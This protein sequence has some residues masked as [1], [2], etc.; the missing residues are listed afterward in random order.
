MSFTTIL[1]SIE[2]TVSSCLPLLKKWVEINSFSKNLQGL[3]QMAHSLFQD[4]SILKGEQELISLPSYP[5]C[6]P[7]GSLMHCETGLALR[8][9]KRPDAARQIFLAGHLDTVH[10]PSSTFQMLREQSATRWIGPGTADMKG[11]LFILLMA[12]M[13][14]EASF[15]ADRLGWEILITPDEEIG[16]ASSLNLL[17]EAAGR[18]QT[19]L[20]FEPAFPDGAFVSSRK[21][22]ATY[23]VVCRGQAAHVGREYT[24]GKSAVY[25]LAEWITAVEQLGAKYPESILNVAALEAKAPPNVVPDLS[26]CR[27]N[28]RSSS[29]ADMVDIEQELHQIA[30]RCNRRPGIRM[31]IERESFRGPKPFD[32][33]TETLFKEYGESAAC[34][35]IPFH[36]RPT[37]GV[38]DGNFLSEAGMAVLDSAGAVGGHIHTEEEYMDLPSITER[39]KLTALFLMKRAE[40]EHG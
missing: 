5:R 7:D 35:G 12:M 11:G 1:Q 40:A 8:I 26:I 23:A 14:F 28:S 39:A 18:Y 33:K 17:L 19:G 22:S 37:G 38:C 31:T 6:G 15:R 24:A 30:A 13:A 16:S 29:R 3:H 27:I 20:L 36:V 9:R 32:S 10:A 34:L 21:G 4:F 2:E 25:A